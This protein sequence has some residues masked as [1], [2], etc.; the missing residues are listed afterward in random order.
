MC[1]TRTHR[2]HPMT[3]HDTA[4]KQR[5]GR[6]PVRSG[7]RPAPPR[8]PERQ[9]SPSSSASSSRDSAPGRGPRPGPGCRGCAPD[10]PSR[11]TRRRSFPSSAPGRPSPGSRSGPR[12]GRQGRSAPGRPGRRPAAPWP[13]VAL[14]G[15]RAHQRH[16]LLDRTHREPLGHD[17]VRQPVLLLRV[18]HGEQ[19]PRVPGGEHS[20]GDPP[21]HRRRE[22]Q[23]PQRVGDLRTRAPDPVGQLV[24][25]AVEVLAAAGRRRLPPPAGSAGPG[26][27]SPAARP[28]AASRRPWPGRSPGSAPGRPHGRP[29]SGA[30]P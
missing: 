4:R 9:L 25:R 15:S 23:Q 11:R 2:I 8:P 20:G 5:A 12:A 17:A 26:A 14:C 30:R 24:V 3:R 1:H 29:A 27:G 22:L 10:P 19:R 28:G 18:L 7:T 21:L 16:D 6:V 13:C